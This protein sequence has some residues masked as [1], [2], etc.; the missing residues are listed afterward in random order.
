MDVQS[1]IN[2]PHTRVKLIAL[3]HT[4]LIAAALNSYWLPAA[5]Q[6][7]NI[8]F[9][10]TLFWAIHSRQSSDAVQIAC[11]INVIGFLLDLFGIILYFPSKGAILSAVF[12]IFNLALRPFTLLLLHRELTDRGGS[13]SLATETTGNN[14][15]NYEDIDQQHQVFTPTILS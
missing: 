7:Y 4:C 1:A 11:F 5:Y 9:I 14:P 8:I 10:I 2:T 12:A 3:I 13:L 6:F 15:S